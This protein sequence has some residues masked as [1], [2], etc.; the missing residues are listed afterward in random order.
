MVNLV[1]LKWLK[2][3]QQQ[4]KEMADDPDYAVMIKDALDKDPELRE[5]LPHIYVMA[6]RT[7]ESIGKK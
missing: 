7:I 6:L 2:R 5:E 1:D 3:C 4:L